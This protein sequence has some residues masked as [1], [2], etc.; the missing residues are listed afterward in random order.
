MHYSN[1][2]SMVRVD[3]FRTTGKWY[4][5]FEVNMRDHYDALNI[6]EAV[7]LCWIKSSGMTLSKD[8]FLVCLE[9]YHRNS[10]PVAVMYRD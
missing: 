6:V 5:T 4:D 3:R 2:P 10:Y 1:D 7:L 8:F 9:P